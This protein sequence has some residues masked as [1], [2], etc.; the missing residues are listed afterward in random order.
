MFFEGVL[1]EKNTCFS[2][3]CS[4]ALSLYGLF[5]TPCV[6]SS[7]H[8]DNGVN[9]FQGVSKRS[10]AWNGL[11]DAISIVLLSLLLTLI[12]LLLAWKLAVHQ[13]KLNSESRR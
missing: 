2:L 10:V 11:L 13:K 4:T 12:A 7:R 5:V 6:K 1:V 9:P 8:Q 3:E